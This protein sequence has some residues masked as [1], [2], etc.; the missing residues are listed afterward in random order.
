MEYEAFGPGRHKF[1]VGRL[2][3]AIARMWASRWAKSPEITI[4]EK[5][6]LSELF[7]V[8]KE[9]V[10]QTIEITWPFYSGKRR[11]PH[12]SNRKSTNPYEELNRKIQAKGRER[13]SEEVQKR[14]A[15]SI[16]DRARNLKW[17]AIIYYDYLMKLLPFA[18]PIISGHGTMCIDSF[19]GKDDERY[20]EIHRMNLAKEL[21]AAAFS[22]VGSN[23]KAYPDFTLLGLET[24]MPIVHVEVKTR[25]SHNL[26]GSYDHIP[27]EQNV[28][29]S[30]YAAKCMI[31]IIVEN[32][33][34]KG[35]KMLWAFAKDLKSGLH[36]NGGWGRDM[37]HPK[38]SLF[39]D[40]DKEPFL[41]AL[42]KL[43]I[44]KV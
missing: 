18:Q 41:D 10:E 32:Y 6:L 33:E 31:V 35:H 42:A 30:K 26:F 27:V 5:L 44:T 11:K 16:E 9:R 21:S 38:L 36:F 37:Y 28:I 15:R 19:E 34:N 23:A 40:E 22:E 29:E 8:S 2:E 25:G 7:E 20:N 17:E 1:K 12:T 13:T 4:D 24:H 43:L 3:W 39:H 14:Q